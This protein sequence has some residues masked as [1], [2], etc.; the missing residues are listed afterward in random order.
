MSFTASFSAGQLQSNLNV[1]RFTDTSSGTDS[2]I[3]SRI[4]YITNA[5]G[6]T[7]AYNWSYSDNYLDV[8][9]LTTDMAVSC[10]VDWIDVDGVTVLYTITNVYCFDGR[11]K[12]FY[13]ELAQT[14]N[15]LP[16]VIQNTNFYSNS[17]VF[18]TNLKCAAYA[19]QFGAN[20]KISQAALNRCTEMSNRQAKY[21]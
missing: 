1:A 14:P 20:I 12:E 13:Y 15:G 8:S 17:G 7:T 16:P 5:A 21:F 4:L 19:V 18:Y 2:N 10:R 11:N 6:T 3:G 9:F